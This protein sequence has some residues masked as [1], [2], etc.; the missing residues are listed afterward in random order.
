MGMYGMYGSLWLC[1]G[2][3]GYY[4]YVWVVMGQ[5]GY[6]WVIMGMYGYVNGVFLYSALSSSPALKRSL[7][8]TMSG[9][10]FCAHPWIDRPGGTSVS[11]LFRK[12]RLYGIKHLAQGYT[13]MTRGRDSNSLV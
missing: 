2:Q 7:V 12:T 3:Y 4:G 11:S 6:V 5:Y 10:H 9:L 13:I 1:M 8:Y